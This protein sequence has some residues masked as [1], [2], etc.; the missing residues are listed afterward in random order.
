MGRK[1][2]TCWIAC[3]AWLV[4]M[5]AG[6]RAEMYVEGYAGYV[7]AATVFRDY[8]IMTTHHPTLGTY[9]EHHTRG[10]FRPSVI[11]GA[12]V[13]TWFTQQGFL[14]APYPEWMKYL[15]FYMDFSY[16]P[17]N[18]RT[19]V[20][21]SIIPGSALNTRNTF[22]SNGNTFTLAFMFAGRYGF[23]KDDEVPFGRLQPYFAVGPALMFTTQDVTLESNALSGG[24]FVPFKINPGAETAVVPALV[25]EPGMRWMVLKSVSLDLSFKFRWA[26]PSFTFKYTDPISATSESFTLHPQYLIL[27]FQLG[28]AYHF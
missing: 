13:G 1:G 15:G 25:I 18:F 20:G 10:T 11:G 28:A 24:E 3:L 2:I 5:P 12:K 9:E 27:S 21:N 4:M 23:L 8:L 16:H 7:R 19:R 26:H 14:K 17:Q 6:T 22:S